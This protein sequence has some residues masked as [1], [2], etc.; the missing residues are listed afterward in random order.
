MT[1]ITFT[2]ALIVT[3]VG[4][5]ASAQSL[6]LSVADP[7]GATRDYYCTSEGEPTLH[8]PW[9]CGAQFASDCQRLGGTMSEQ[10]EWGGKVCFMPA[11]AKLGGGGFATRR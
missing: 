11:S 6:R 4:T 7:G 2:A 3:L 5:A 10:K 9:K 8:R 1:R